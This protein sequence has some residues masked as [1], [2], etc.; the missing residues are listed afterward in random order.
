MCVQNLSKFQTVILGGNTF[1]ND[2][3]LCRPGM[4]DAEA[5]GVS[6]NGIKVADWAEAEFLKKIRVER[7]VYFCF[8]ARGIFVLLLFAAIFVFVFN[9]QVE[10]QSI[11]ASELQQVTKRTNASDKIREHALKHEKEVEQISE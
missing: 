8:Q 9:H 11:A 5:I 4:E 7:R 3:A 2:F 1:I 10:V 6:I